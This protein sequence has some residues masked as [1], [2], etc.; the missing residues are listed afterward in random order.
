MSAKMKT[1]KGAAKRFKITKRGKIKHYNQ[2][3]SHLMSNKSARRRRS[4][5]KPSVLSVAKARR[6]VRMINAAG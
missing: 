2:G 6:I 5:R 3:H 1:H 4:M